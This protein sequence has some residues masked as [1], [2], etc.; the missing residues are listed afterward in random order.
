MTRTEAKKKHRKRAARQ[1]AAW[2]VVIACE[3]LAAALPA[4]IAAAILLPAA[5]AERGYSA[6]GSE[7]VLVAMVFCTA[8]SI[9]HKWVCKKIFE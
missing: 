9:I 8:Y 3:L 1:M 2:A 4:A 6:F 5:Y 7:H